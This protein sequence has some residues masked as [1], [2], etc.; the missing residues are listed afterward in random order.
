MKYLKSFNESFESDDLMTDEEL[1]QEVLQR[2]MDYQINP[3]I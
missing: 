1:K 3:F 2:I